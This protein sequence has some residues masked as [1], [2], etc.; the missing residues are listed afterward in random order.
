MA[1]ISRQIANFSLGLKYE[2]RLRGPHPPD[3]I[4]RTPFELT[5]GCGPRKR[6]EIR[7]EKKPA[8]ED[9]WFFGKRWQA[10]RVEAPF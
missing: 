9:F 3:F 6:S 8:P 7:S 4:R 10:V 1:S 2:D 5:V